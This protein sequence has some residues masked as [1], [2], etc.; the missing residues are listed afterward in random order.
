[1]VARGIT[2]SMSFEFSG[3][4]NGQLGL[5]PKSFEGFWSHRFWMNEPVTLMF[6]DQEF[7]ILSDKEVGPKVLHDWPI[8]LLQKVNIG[9]P[10]S[11][12]PQLDFYF[13]DGSMVTIHQFGLRLDELKAVQHKVRT[14]IAEKRGSK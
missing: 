5:T 9:Y 13:K 11:S 1:M 7:R 4:P 10:S 6:D 14:L 12:S 3:S 8:T 2:I